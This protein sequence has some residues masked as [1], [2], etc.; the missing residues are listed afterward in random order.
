MLDGSSA[1]Q[2]K[3]MKNDDR[4][5]ARSQCFQGSRDGNQVA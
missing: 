3:V 4:I 2:T 1:V 5:R